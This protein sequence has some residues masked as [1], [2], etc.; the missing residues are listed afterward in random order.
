MWCSGTW[1]SGGFGS[2]WFTVELSDVKGL[3]FLFLK[4][5]ILCAQWSS[6][7]QVLRRQPGGRTDR[8]L[9]SAAGSCHRARSAG[10]GRIIQL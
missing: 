4:E 1:F 8:Q 3:F 9:F 6:A 10:E 2:I 5:M 7:V